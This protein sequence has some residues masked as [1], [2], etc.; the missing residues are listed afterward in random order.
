MISI[1]GV[2]KEE[3]RNV[4]K[5]MKIVGIIIT[6]V[7]NV[8]A[9]KNLLCQLGQQKNIAVES[10]EKPIIVNPQNILEFVE[11]VQKHF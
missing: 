7:I 2:A 10:V 5:M 1:I 9:V 4:F 11:Y 6:V 8:P 3:L